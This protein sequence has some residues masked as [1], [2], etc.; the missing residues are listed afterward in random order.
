[1]PHPSIE[2]V[3]R[4]DFRE[5]MKLEWLDANG[6]GGYA[7]STIFSCHTRKYHG[8]LVTNL[9]DPAGRF[10][11]LSK[12]EDSL[13]SKRG[14]LF[15]SLHRYPGVLF[16]GMPAGLREFR[17]DPCPSFVYAAEDLRIRKSLLTVHGKDLLLVRYDLEEGPPSAVLCI[18]PLLAFRGYHDLARENPFFR[19]G[20]Q[21]RKNGFRIDPYEGMPPLF[22]QTNV[23]SSF[24]PSPAWY[25]DFVYEEERARGYDWKEDLVMPGILEI[26]IRKG[27]GAIVSVSLEPRCEQIKKTWNREIE[28]RAEARN[29]DEDWARRFVPEE[30]R[31]LVSSL[32]AASRQFLI[33]GPHGRPAI[34]AGYHWFGAWGRDTL[35]SL[36]GL[37][38]CLGRHREGLEILTALGGQERDGVLPNILSDD[39]EGGAYNTVDASLL[40]FWAVQQML[41]FGGDPE[42]V[43]ADL[44]PVMKRIL[45]RYAEGTIWGIHAAENGLLSAGSAQTHLTWMDAV[46]D[47]KP[48]TPRCG[49]AVDINALWYNALCFASELSRRFGDD[50]FAFDEYIGRFQNS[51]VDTFW[52]GAGGYLGDTWDN[53]VLDISLRPNMILAVSLPHSPL[54]AEKRALVVRAVQEDLLTPRG[55]RTLS[56]KDPSYRGRCAGD[57]ASRDSAYHQGTV[58][59]WLLSP[60]GE[61]YL[62]VSE[63]RSRARSFL[64]A[65]LRDFLRS[66]LHEAGLGSISEIFDGDPPHEARGC[67]AQAWSVAGVLRLYRILSD[68]ADR[69]QT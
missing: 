55:L 10:V 36:P 28:R 66:H 69:P 31:T 9:R 1:M 26:P 32:L 14:E 2:D 11:L 67:I 57:Q 42:E 58:W 3:Q 45:Q 41:Q 27:V 7:S 18:K 40:F 39:G 61:A 8:L 24:R 19:G 59:P 34:V 25:R 64:T 53:G 60:F 54:D 51:F 21:D 65:L 22:V 16:P 38:F 48:V 33:R 29:Q 13:R 43:R 56:P 5:A 52:Y 47:G 17:L 6:T 37:T 12:F 50:F 63:D 62:K 23:R 35:W 15:L 4:L 49:F 68:A 46:V 30:D 20:I 44:W